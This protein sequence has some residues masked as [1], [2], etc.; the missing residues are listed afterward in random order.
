MQMYRLG[1]D[2]WILFNHENNYYT[3]QT[4]QVVQSLAAQPP[5]VTQRTVNFLLYLYY[6][7]VH[8]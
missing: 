2:I 1:T 4:V 8:G 3:L 7:P 5:T 6:S